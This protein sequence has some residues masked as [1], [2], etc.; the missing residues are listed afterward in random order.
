MVEVTRLEQLV[1]ELAV[2]E[3]R[4]VQALL[5]AL[6]LELLLLGGR[7]GVNPIIPSR[8]RKVVTEGT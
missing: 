3:Q 1:A 8:R 4:H 2:A 6:Q 7:L 5:R